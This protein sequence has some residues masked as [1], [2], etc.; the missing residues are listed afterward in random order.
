MELEKESRP[1]YNQD[2]DSDEDCPVLVSAVASSKSD[3]HAKVP[4]R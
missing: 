4:G 1:F 3:K 2:E